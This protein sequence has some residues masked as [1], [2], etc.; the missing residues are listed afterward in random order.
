LQSRTGKAPAVVYH[1]L[2]SS[3]ISST[4]CPTLASLSGLSGAAEMLGFKEKP[5]SYESKAPLQEH[6]VGW[7]PM[8]QE[9][10]AQLREKDQVRTTRR[11]HLCEAKRGQAEGRTSH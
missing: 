6:E 1:V 8:P 7:Q 9:K 10:V 5:P 2:L 3:N 11:P 4:L